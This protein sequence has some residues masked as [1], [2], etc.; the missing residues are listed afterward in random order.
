MSSDEWMIADLFVRALLLTV[1]AG[2]LALAARHAYRAV[3]T[4]HAQGV[5]RLRDYEASR[6]LR[7]RSTPLATVHPLRP[8]SVEGD[9]ALRLVRR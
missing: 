6:L 9:R 8:V 2:A 7:Y 3:R 5:A 1:L 4:F